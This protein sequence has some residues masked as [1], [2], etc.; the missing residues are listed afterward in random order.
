MAIEELELSMEVG[1]T[2]SECVTYT[3][4]NGKDFR[5]L[6]FHGEAAFDANAAV[7]LIWIHNHDTEDEDVL[8]TIK[9]SGGL[10][11]MI[12]RTDAD[13][14]RKLALCLDNG[15]GGAVY[16]SGHARIF[17]ED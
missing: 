7:E 8:W 16:M 4:A 17:V 11:H 15:L 13:G 6:S 9:G 14:T 1:A 3:P 2:T 10:A 12:R 5:V